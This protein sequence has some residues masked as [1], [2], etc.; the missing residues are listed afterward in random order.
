M[1][2]CSRVLFLALI[3]V[4]DTVQGQENSTLKQ[5]N[6]D[7]N[8]NV[9][10]VDIVTLKPTFDSINEDQVEEVTEENVVVTT[11]VEDLLIQEETTNSY[12]DEVVTTENDFMTTTISDLNID[13]ESVT[14]S[15]LIETTTDYDVE[16]TTVI[17]DLLNDELVSNNSLSTKESFSAEDAISKQEV[18]KE[19]SNSVLRKCYCNANEIWYK[20]KCVSQDTF[21]LVLENQETWEESKY[22][23]TDFGTIEVSKLD[24]PIN[25]LKINLTYNLFYLLP[26]GKI[27][28]DEYNLVFNQNKSCIEHGKD[29]N[30]GLTWAAQVCLPPQNIKFCC[31]RNSCSKS[32]N[33]SIYFPMVVVDGT[34]ETWDYISKENVKIKCKEDEKLHAPVLGFDNYLRYTSHGVVLITYVDMHDVIISPDEFCV[35]RINNKET[36]ANYFVAKFCF[37]DVEYERKKRCNNGLCIRKCCEP[38]QIFEMETGVCIEATNETKWNMELHDSKS[39]QIYDKKTDFVWDHG[40]PHC[41]NGLYTLNPAENKDDEHFLLNNGSLYVHSYKNSV[42]ATKFCLDNVKM[43][44]TVEPQAMLCFPDVEYQRRRNC[45]GNLCIR[46]CCEPNEVFEMQSGYCI[47]ATN[48][49]RWNFDLYDNETLKIDENNTDYVWEVGFPHCKHDFY[50]L[51]PNE[52]KNDKYILLTNGSLHVFSYKDSVTPMKFCLD[53]FII[54]DSVLP[55]AMVCF[56]EAEEEVT[57]CQQVQAQLYPSLLVVSCLFL[58]ATLFVYASIPELH[59]KVHGKSLVSHVFSLLVAYLCLVTV[60]W[61]SSLLNMSICIFMGKFD[62]S[63][64]YFIY[65]DLAF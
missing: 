54:G 45:E 20:G 58:T 3:L 47:Q 28:Y 19:M 50:A 61:G 41:K 23:S 40:L 17:V 39:L 60:Q 11:T 14:I 26:D 59:A 31:E 42:D 57:Q 48:E 37:P 55:Q 63:F 46:K 43:G 10:S 35:Q 15:N 38:N 16:A 36:L 51:S 18:L 25:Y 13:V 8:L 44:D 52:E 29:E 7:N 64:N 12:N 9:S 56:P 30:G 34:D 49:T 21:I 22:R 65:Q 2:F 62:Y 24:C 53:N 4:L 32:S 1:I 5:F 6:N 27:L 33:K